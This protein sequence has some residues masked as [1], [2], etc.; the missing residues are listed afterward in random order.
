MGLSLE[1]CAVVADELVRWGD[2]DAFG[3]VNNTLYFRYFETVR[4]AYFERIGFRA[5][6][7]GAGIGPILASTACRFR[8]PLGYPDRLRVGARVS[9]LG[10][11]RL[12]MEYV[13]YSEA[14]ADVA[15]TGEGVIVSYDYDAGRKCPLPAPVREAIARLEPSLAGG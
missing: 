14:L 4:I 1:T 3:H 11:D 15:A 9:T 10:E 2:L 13:V 8:R 5:G 12:T 7:A 6:G